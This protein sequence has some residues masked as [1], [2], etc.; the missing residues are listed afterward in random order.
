[1]EEG[2]SC[3][4][5]GLFGMLE[6]PGLGEPFVK[7]SSAYT[8]FGSSRFVPITNRDPWMVGGW[9]RDP[10]EAWPYKALKGGLPRPFMKRRKK[11][12]EGKLNMSQP[13]RFKGW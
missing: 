4:C 5:L 8:S 11:L 7:A 6:Q 12:G 13:V 2:R 9:L 10:S 1:M 3:L